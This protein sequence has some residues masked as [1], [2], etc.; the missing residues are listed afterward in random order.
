MIA[1]VHL[2]RHVLAGFLV[3]WW[4]SRFASYTNAHLG[5]GIS[6][7]AHTGHQFP[8]DQRYLVILPPSKSLH[9]NGRIWK[10]RPDLIRPARIPPL[11]KSISTFWQ[12]K[13]RPNRKLRFQNPMVATSHD[14]KSVTLFYGGGGKEQPPP[15]HP[16]N[17]VWRLL[18]INH[19][20]PWYRSSGIWRC[21]SVSLHPMTLQ[22]NY[23]TVAN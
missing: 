5:G 8:S 22:P 19:Y 20:L 6:Q 17:R 16:W 15:W 1:A 21:R 2:R 11:R 14:R 7:L 18:R 12:R 3:C 9:H 23:A 13:I 4:L 10:I